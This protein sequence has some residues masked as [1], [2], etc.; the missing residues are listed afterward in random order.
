MLKY[1]LPTIFLC[2][3]TTYATAGSLDLGFNDDSFKVG[4]EHTINQDNYGSV[5]VGGTFL[6]N[7]DSIL[8]NAG[9]D[10]VGNP[11]NLTGLNLGIGT[12]IYAGNTDSDFDFINLAIGVRGD[13]TFPQLQ[14]IG[15]AAH[16]Y[17][18]PKVFSWQ[19]AER[20]LDTEARIT[21]A[22]VPKAKLFIAYQFINLGIEDTNN[23]YRIDESIRIGFTASF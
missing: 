2:L 21:Y 22:I 6:Y 20:L 7:E 11:G 12:K 10:F 15:M 3:F 9:L 19:D 1:I 8:G 16:I 17:Y 18:A 14:G 23:D 5:V 13:Y 4:Y